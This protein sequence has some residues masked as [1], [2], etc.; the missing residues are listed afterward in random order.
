MPNLCDYI[1]K[2]TGKRKDVHTFIGYLDNGYHYIKDSDLTSEICKASKENYKLHFISKDKK[3]HLFTNDKKHMY[4][5]FDVY[6][7]EEGQKDRG[8]LNGQK[9]VAFLPYDN[10]QEIKMP[11]PTKSGSSFE[12]RE[13]SYL[14]NPY[15]R[16]T[17]PTRASGNKY[18]ASD[19]YTVDGDKVFKV[20]WKTSPSNQSSTPGYSIP[21]TGVE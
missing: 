19:P 12:Y 1:M 11:A 17:S 14:L 7:L 3:T 13:E 10:G 16:S 2:V 15:A 6:R 5:V 8:T 21:K 18:Y 4:R 20:V 9:G